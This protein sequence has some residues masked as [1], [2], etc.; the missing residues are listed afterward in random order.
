MPSISGPSRR[1]TMRIKMIL[2]VRRT[3]CEPVSFKAPDFSEGD[4]A[5]ERR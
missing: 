4:R 1:A 3:T 2:N 5:S